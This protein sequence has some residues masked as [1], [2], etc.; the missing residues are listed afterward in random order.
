MDFMFEDKECQIINIT[1][2]TAYT[3]LKKEE[4]TNRLLKTLN[5]SV[6]HEMVT[7]VKTMI[8]IS[9]RLVKKLAKFPQEKRMVETMLLS[10]QFIMMHAHDFLD[11]QLI[12]HGNFKPYF[13]TGYL[14]DAIAEIVQMMNFSVHKR[15]LKIQ[16]DRDLLESSLLK[17]DKR[18]L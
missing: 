2:L 6:H 8:E 17:F 14:E 15:D 11:Q 12:E 3:K 10:S 18:R 7:P 9:E 13:D 5:T 16:F 4:D 1:D